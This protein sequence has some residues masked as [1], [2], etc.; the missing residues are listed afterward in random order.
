MNSGLTV[1]LLFNLL[2]SFLT[3][4]F[5]I[6]KSGRKDFWLV[7][8]ISFGIYFNFFGLN[9]IQSFA[10]YLLPLTNLFFLVFSNFVP[11]TKIKYYLVFW[12]ISTF[13]FGIYFFQIFIFPIK[14]NLSHTIFSDMNILSYLTIHFGTALS[15]S[16]RLKILFFE[17]FIYI[18]TILKRYFDYFS[19]WNVT[20]LLG[21][22]GLILVIFGLKNTIKEDKNNLKLL[23]GNF[24]A[25]SSVIMLCRSVN[26]NSIWV[27]VSPLIVYIALNVTKKILI[28]IALISQLLW[29]V[30]INNYV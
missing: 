29:L 19:I 21:L 8:L 26:T 5:F 27:L 4:V 28:P 30:F 2:I 24:L 22:G 15:I 11:A 16:T 25:I 23:L 7:L 6:K 14:F 10:Y 12:F 13:V 9:T 1:N 3:A 17:V 20:N 18:Y